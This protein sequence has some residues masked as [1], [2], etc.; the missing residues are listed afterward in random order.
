[1]CASKS[2]WP[3]RTVELYAL[4]LQKLRGQRRRRPASPLLRVQN[5]HIRRWVAQMH[6][7]GRSG[8]GIALILSGWRG[9]Y[10]WLGREGLVA[11]NP[12]Q[13]V[14][15]PKAPKPLPKALGVD[16]AVQL[17]GFERRTTADPWLEARD[18]AIVEL[19][20]GCGL[21]VGELVGLDVRGQR[22]RR[23]AGSTCRPARPMCWARAASGAAC[24]SGGKALEALQALAGAAR[25]PAAGMQ[26][27]AG[28]V[29]RPARHAADGRRRIWQ[30]LKQR[31]LQAGL[32][33]PVHPHMLRH[34][35]ASHVLQ[36]S[37]DLRAVQE[38]LGHA[39]ITTTQVYTRLDFQHLAKAYD[40]AHPRAHAA[41]NR[42]A[43]VQRASRCA[44]LASENTARLLSGGH[45]GQHGLQ[46]L[47]AGRPRR[48]PSIGTSACATRTCATQ[49]I[50][51]VRE[52]HQA[53]RH[54]ARAA[55]ATSSAVNGPSSS[56]P[57]RWSDKR[58]T[59]SIS[60]AARQQPARPRAAAVPRPRGGRRSR[61]DL[62]DVGDVHQ[63]HR[64]RGSFRRTERAIMPDQPL[65]E[66]WAL[67]RPVAGSIRSRPWMRRLFSRRCWLR[68]EQASPAA[69]AARWRCRSAC[70]CMRPEAHGIRP[71]ARASGKHGRRAP[72]A[73]AR[74]AAT[75]RSGRR[76]APAQPMAAS[77][78]TAPM[79]PRRRAPSGRPR[80][81]GSTSGNGHRQ[82]HRPS[83]AEAH[84]QPVE[85]ARAL[86]Q[87]HH[88]GRRTSSSAA[89]ASHAAA[90]ATRC[91]STEASSGHRCRP[92]D[93]GQGRPA[94]APIS[95]H[96]SART[97]RRPRSRSD[98][99]AEQRQHSRQ[100]GQAEVDAQDQRGA[101]LA[102]AQVA[103][104]DEAAAAR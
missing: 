3:Q 7:A 32:A 104:A 16:D 98:D 63:Q 27:A 20:Y 78:A 10:T 23:A 57:K 42:R 2:G 72:P 61:P 48:S 70:A 26:R 43:R 53:A 74:A 68:S 87:R 56:M 94:S 31:S 12:V 91:R 71:A 64:A 33:T 8:R 89:A 1:M 28:A 100:A 41:R 54:H 50:G 62:L 25:L 77:A 38:L 101:L 69:P 24:R 44:G 39:N 49:S 4:D 13:D 66:D 84:Q 14:R 5:A 51:L 80:S 67:I 34:S 65:G 22:Q 82:R 17:A 79:A 36:S 11:S 81:D 35:F 6:G 52:G 55:A 59:L 93:A 15:A 92:R 85:R 99:G 96:A 46:P 9:F 58:A 60:R 19:L 30:R 45:G 37:G 21:R 95:S 29:H 47:R 18:A 83:A 73:P 86:A 88:G 102:A 40:A 90:P 103:F 76:G 97:S 75:A